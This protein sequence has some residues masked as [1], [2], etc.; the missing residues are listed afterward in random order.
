MIK[1]IDL[2]EEINK[3]QSIISGNEFKKKYLTTD[4]GKLEKSFFDSEEDI[5]FMGNVLG[6]GSYYSVT[7][8]SSAHY[9][10]M[11][12]ILVHRI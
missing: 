6:N 9:E 2:L 7:A 3:R 10:E 8:D 1:L 12:I 5:D 4:S 11:I